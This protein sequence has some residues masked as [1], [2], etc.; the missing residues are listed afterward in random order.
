MENIDFLHLDAEV[1]ISEK[2]IKYGLNEIMNLTGMPDSN[3]LVF[4]CSG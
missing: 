4:Y 1:V 2:Y 3:H